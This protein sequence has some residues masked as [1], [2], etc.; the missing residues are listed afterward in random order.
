MSEEDWTD[1]L[2]DLQVG[3]GTAMALNYKLEQQLKIAVEA[4]EKLLEPLKDEP[5][6]GG[7]YWLGSLGLMEARQALA[8]IKELDND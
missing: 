7:S 8:K 2:S 1:G 6:E 5:I 4:L 3:F